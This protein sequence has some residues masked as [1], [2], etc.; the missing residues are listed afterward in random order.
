MAY[1]EPGIEVRYASTTTVATLNEPFL[2]PCIVCQ[3]LNT[4]KR[5]SLLKEVW[6]VMLMK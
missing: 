1:K 2:T 5:Q 4:L 3:L 6:K